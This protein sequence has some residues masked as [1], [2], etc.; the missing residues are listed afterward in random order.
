V[1][2]KFKHTCLLVMHFKECFLFYRD[3]LGFTV[4]HGSSQES[5]ADF[6][7][8]AA[9]LALFARQNISASL[10]TTGL[11]AMAESQ[12]RVRIIFTVQDVDAACLELPQKGVQLVEGPADRSDWAART[13]TF[14]DPDGSLVEIDHPIPS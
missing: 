2:E 6:D 7:A 9:I 1:G 11:L 3:V 12:D 13:A 14:R 10:G 4:M 5:Y 8:G